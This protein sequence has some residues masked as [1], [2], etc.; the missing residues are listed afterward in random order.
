[1]IA[2]SEKCVRYSVAVMPPLP[3]SSMSGSFQC[4]GPA[5]WA[6]A[7]FACA[8]PIID[9]Q[10]SEMSPVVRHRFPT[11]SPHVHT[12]GSVRPHSQIEYTIGRPVRANASRI[13][14]YRCC[15]STPWLLQLSY[16]R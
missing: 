12:F 8:L 15:A 13:A 10:L 14:L 9:D 7:R 16:F 5:Y 1:M 4:P 6:S 3:T 2:H 11:G